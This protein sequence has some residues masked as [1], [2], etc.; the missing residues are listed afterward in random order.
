MAEFVAVT[1]RPVPARQQRRAVARAQ[2]VPAPVSS[3]E[4]AS[5][6]R[7]HVR[8]LARHDGLHEYPGHARC[9]A[10]DAH[11]GR[12]A[13]DVIGRPNKRAPTRGYL[14]GSQ[15]IGLTTGA[16]PELVVLRG[17]K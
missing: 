2:H 1:V 12:N 8:A 16:A 13:D 6:A 15:V 3:Q 10:V 14:R 9:P 4:L 11:D 17:V 5:S 7:L